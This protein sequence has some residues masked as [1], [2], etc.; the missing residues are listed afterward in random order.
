MMVPAVA[1]L[2]SQRIL[3]VVS[4]V[5]IAWLLHVNM[6]D[7]AINRR[8]TYYSSGNRPHTII[9]GWESSPLPSAATAP[10]MQPSPSPFNPQSVQTLP[11]GITMFDVKVTGLLTQRSTSRKEGLYV[12]VLLPLAMLIAAIYLWLGGRHAARIARGLCANCGYDLKGSPESAHCPECGAK[13]AK[14]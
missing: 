7:W 4:L 5:F 10:I 12:G 2:R 9:C 8:A 6:C 1:M 3:I 13:T 14:A 11:R